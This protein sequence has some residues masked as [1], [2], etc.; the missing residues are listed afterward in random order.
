MHNPTD[1]YYG[2]LSAHGI[3]ILQRP[4]PEIHLSFSSR[5]AGL[6]HCVPHAVPRL[7]RF[8]VGRLQIPAFWTRRT[9][10]RKRALGSIYKGHVIA[11]ERLG[12]R[13]SPSLPFTIHQP[14]A[15]PVQRPNLDP[16][17]VK[18]RRAIARA[19]HC[20]SDHCSEPQLKG[21]PHRLAAPV[22]AAQHP[23]LVLKCTGTCRSPKHLPH[24]ASGPPTQAAQRCRRRSDRWRLGAQSETRAS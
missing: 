21:F 11:P 22:G 14:S 19:P 17:K 8:W 6:L 2:S 9:S 5:L 18:A 16:P 12:P 20:A 7:T 15:N 3:G 13:H 10:I 23:R 4:T 24:D 1:I